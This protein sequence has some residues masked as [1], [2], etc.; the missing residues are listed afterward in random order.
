MG[1]YYIPPFRRCRRIFFRIFPSKTEI[2]A[3]R[4]LIAAIRVNSAWNLIFIQ[5]KHHAH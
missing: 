1:A 5:R 4:R 2:A 3:D